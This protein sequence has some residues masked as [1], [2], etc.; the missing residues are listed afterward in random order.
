MKQI[1]NK[2]LLIDD[3]VNINETVSE[4][5][6]FKK[7]EVIAVSNGQEALEVLKDWTPN[8]I[9]CDVFMPVMDGFKFHQVISENKLWSSI[10]F[11]FL[12]A[13]DQDEIR[14]NSLQLGADEFISKPFVLNDLA[15]SI[16]TKIERF[17]KIKAGTVNF[18]GSDS[19]LPHEVN[20]PLNGIIGIANLLVDHHET[21][22]KD[23]AVLLYKAM[24]V[25]GERLNRTMR[26]L[27]LYHQIIENKLVLETDLSSNILEVYSK[28]L[29]QLHF[30]YDDIA[31]FISSDLEK[32]TLKISP[33][34]LSIILYEL[35][36]NA[37]KFSNNK[38][39]SITGKVAHSGFYEVTIIDQGIGL[40]EDELSNINAGNQFRRDVREQ[41]GLGLGLYL[42]KTILT[43]VQG[44][45]SI[46]S[47]ADVETKV[48]VSIPIFE[49]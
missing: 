6:T 9:L 26:N 22:E 23:Q 16:E 21:L 40:S 20:T 32:A 7:Y 33:N 17:Q 11:F 48:V 18:Y 12:T 13:N 1:K 2:I 30:I 5:L 41:Q 43:M 27:L 47:T 31:I 29:Q 10:P 49:N 46:T 45:L 8:L 35:L 37:L 3:D 36:D 15:N 38:E 4:F 39:A 24:K 28:T 34:Y 25:S 14:K 19:Y 44:K 42:S